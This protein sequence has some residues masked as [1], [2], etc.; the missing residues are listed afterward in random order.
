MV[1]VAWKL[2]AL[3][4]VAACAQLYAVGMARV[5]F[6]DFIQELTEVLGSCSGFY[7]RKFSWRPQ[8]W[9]LTVCFVIVRSRLGFEFCYHIGLQPT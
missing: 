7:F 4:R 2:P 6:G 3:F 9:K 8:C 5:V 1:V